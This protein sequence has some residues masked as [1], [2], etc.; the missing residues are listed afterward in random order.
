MSAASKI[1]GFRS[2]L[3]ISLAVKFAVFLVGVAI[4]G[5]HSTINQLT[6][7]GVSGG[8]PP[9]Y[10]APFGDVE[11]YTDYRDLYLRCLV[12]PFLGGSSAYN[13]PIVYNYP[14]LFLYTLAIFAKVN[15]IWFPAI[16]LILFDALTV[17]PVYLIGRDFLFK[18]NQKLAFVISLVWIFNP[19]NLFY[20]DLM[21]LNPAPTTFFLLLAILFFLKKNWIASS[22]ALAVSTGFKQ[23]SV[24]VFPILLIALWKTVGFSRRLFAFVASYIGFLVL[25]S[26]PYIYQNPQQYLWALQLPILGN[27]PGTGNGTPTQFVYNLS[28]PTRLTTFIGLI[29]FTNLQSLAVATYGYLNYAFISIA[30]VLFAWLFLRRS[31]VSKE[32]ILSYSF[33][34]IALFFALFG[35]GVYKYYFLTL[36]PL[37]AL[38]FSS[39]KAM[40][41]FEVFSIALV[42]L[43]REVTPWLAILLITLIPSFGL[44]LG[45][46]TIVSPAVP[47]GSVENLNTDDQTEAT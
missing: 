8:N 12:T 1:F 2:S 39:K 30:I 5:P 7:C 32:E 29:K 37:G 47:P 25:I 14:P 19:I 15:L 46:E 27:P 13:L 31:K 9:V 20:S 41:M 6:E 35:R 38:I 3:L 44:N 26:V 17:I 28:Q 24:L 40:I 16:P 4:I 18:G 42:M 10:I 33:I 22:A 36:T 43:P 21:W 23:I 34:I 11:A 45:G